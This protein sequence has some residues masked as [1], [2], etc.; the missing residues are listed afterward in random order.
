MIRSSA[1]FEQAWSPGEFNLE[2]IWLFL[3]IGS[4]LKIQRLL[5]AG[6]TLGSPHQLINSPF[7]LDR[8]GIG[9]CFLRSFWFFCILYIT[10]F[11]ENLP[12]FTNTPQ[13]FVF[14]KSLL[15]RQTKNVE[16]DLTIGINKNLR[17]QFEKII[18]ATHANSR[19]PSQCDQ[20]A[21]MCQLC[22]PLFAFR[23]LVTKSHI[24]TS[25]CNKTAF[26]S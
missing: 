13:S 11:H 22:D 1:T 26:Y 20:N 10:L 16:K 15:K 18:S 3:D 23:N 14:Y 12:F 17:V 9:R 6:V 19:P 7:M 5:G 24:A 4:R 8:T 2:K 25:W 21:H